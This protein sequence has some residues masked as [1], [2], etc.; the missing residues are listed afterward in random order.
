MKT[1]T[2]LF[3]SYSKLLCAIYRFQYCEKSSREKKGV[4]TSVHLFAIETGR[5]SGRLAEMI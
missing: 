4:V 3:C 5:K 2:L 1:L